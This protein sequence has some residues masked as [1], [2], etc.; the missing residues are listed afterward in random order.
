MQPPYFPV[1]FKEICSHI[2]CHDIQFPNSTVLV[3]HPRGGIL[4]LATDA[5]ERSTGSRAQVTFSR[6][7]KF[8]L[9]ECLVISMYRSN[10][11]EQT[12]SYRFEERPTGQVFV[13]ITDHENE[14][15][16]P[17]RLRRHLRDADLLVMDCQYTR[18]RYD[19]ATAGYGHAT[20]DYVAEVARQVGA[21]RL[22]LTH[23]DPAAT[24]DQ[25]EALVRTAASALE[26][27]EVFGCRD[28]Q[29]VDVGL[30]VPAGAVA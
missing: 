21:R 11:P 27:V 12:I 17:M 28:Y 16:I 25:V 20:P 10:H 26:G 23:H 14:A 6:G 24:D 4:A 9:S 29:E 2:R 3:V 8:D 1:H 18:E 22:G 7:H 5:F 13:F 15:A 19:A 30:P